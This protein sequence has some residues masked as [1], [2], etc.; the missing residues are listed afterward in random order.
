MQK[1]VNIRDAKKGTYVYCGRGSKWGN[2]FVMGAIFKGSEYIPDDVV[3]KYKGKVMDRDIVIELFMHYYYGKRL[4]AYELK[5]KNLGCFCA[6]LPCHTDF[7]IK[8]ANDWKTEWINTEP[9]DLN[10]DYIVAEDNSCGFCDHTELTAVGLQNVADTG[11]YTIN[12]F[13]RCCAKWHGRKPIPEEELTYISQLRKK[14]GIET[15][16][17]G[18]KQCHFC[19]I[20]EANSRKYWGYEGE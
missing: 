14:L 7:L 16:E 20:V 11:R 19:D 8:L 10:W 15:V 5:G 2:P 13:C 3:E 12:H 4:N 1:V 18:E 6:P 9:T 17:C